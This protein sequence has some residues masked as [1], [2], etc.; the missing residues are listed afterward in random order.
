MGC[1]EV[2]LMMRCKNWNLTN[3]VVVSN[4]SAGGI[5]RGFGG[6]ELK[7]AF[8]PVLTLAMEKADID[9]VQFF[10]KNFVHPGDGY[11]WRDG[12]WYVYRGPSF[13]KAIDQGAETF[14]WK[15]KWKGWL[16]PT[17][18]NGTKRVG[19]GVGVH[20]NADVGEDKFRGVGATEA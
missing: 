19:V 10:K 2:Q 13:D 5:I 12:N 6:Q 4:R 17:A 20:G 18:V 11:F 15:S 3:K 9:P 8:L 1:G 16:K 14:G 7:S